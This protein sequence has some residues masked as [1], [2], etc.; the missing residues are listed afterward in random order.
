[1]MMTPLSLPDWGHL[2]AGRGGEECVRS[3]SGSH[4]PEGQSIYR[5]GE[6]KKKEKSW[7][8]TVAHHYLNIPLTRMMNIQYV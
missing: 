7:P 5:P 8:F 6:E 3:S 4:D 1:M 2:P